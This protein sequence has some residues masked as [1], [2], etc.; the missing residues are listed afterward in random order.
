MRCRK[1]MMS[2]SYGKT[3]SSCV[4]SREHTH[5]ETLVACTP[6][7]ITHERTDDIPV[8]IVLLL[9]L[10]DTMQ[11]ILV[12]SSLAL[13]RSVMT[14]RLRG[15]GGFPHVYHRGSRSRGNQ[16]TTREKQA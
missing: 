1:P 11:C 15:H 3:H 7:S 12:I 13:F 8:I 2:T 16:G 10:F 14:I 9:Q 4:C 6:I 5:G